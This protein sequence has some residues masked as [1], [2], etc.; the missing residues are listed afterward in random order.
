MC[1][2]HVELSMRVIGQAVREEPQT[3]SF[4]VVDSDDDPLTVGWATMRRIGV[5]AELETLVAAQ[6]PSMRGSPALADATRVEESRGDLV[7]SEAAEVIESAGVRAELVLVQPECELVVVETKSGTVAVELKSVE[8]SSMEPRSA[9]LARVE[10]KRELNGVSSSEQYLT[11]ETAS[12]VLKLRSAGDADAEAGCQ[13][14]CDGE[15]C[16]QCERGVRPSWDPGERVS[17]LSSRRDCQ[18]LTG[19]KTLGAV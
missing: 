1:T 6:G 11:E 15:Q 14:G 5:L 9:E 2:K 12:W 10:K 4:C 19:R 13:L 8:L 18:A 7:K 16:E 17:R 3:I